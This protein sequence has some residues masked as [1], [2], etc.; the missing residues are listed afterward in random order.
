M[1]QWVIS[2]FKRKRTET[3]EP[4]AEA[5]NHEPEAPKPPLE[6]KLILVGD[7][8]VGKTT[9]VKRHMTGEFQKKYIPTL[10]VEVNRVRFMTNCGPIIFNV[11]DTAG[12]EK[13]GGLRDG[14]YVRSDCA[15]VMFD[16]T[17]RTTYQ[18][19]PNWF[20]DV[21]RAVGK[22]P[23]V[24]VGNKVDV[25]ERQVKAQNITYHR[26]FGIQYYD[27]SA[28]TNF[29]FEK[30]FLWLARQLTKQRELKFV[31]EFA[32]LPKIP[33]CTSAAHISEE[34]AKLKEAQDIPISDDGDDSDL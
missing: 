26:K 32:T 19:V 8:G 4:E 23:S 29:N 17:S 20:Q 28:K 11:W 2:K 34:R 16:V 7:G 21:Q 18:N 6:F 25:A 10:G 33:T 24:L 12:Q 13:F 15:I 30:P 9:L 1:L 14:Y 27:V 31:G 22:I 3:H 5:N